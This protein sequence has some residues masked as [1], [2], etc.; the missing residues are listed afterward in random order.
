MAAESTASAVAALLHWLTPF[1]VWLWL[2]ESL[3]GAGYAL[4]LLVRA[5]RDVRHRRASRLNGALTTAAYANLRR[6]QGRLVIFGI[7]LFIGLCALTLTHAPAGLGQ[8]VLRFAYVLAFPALITLLAVLTRYDE[9]S[10][11]RI[12]RQ[13]ER[14]R[15][16]KMASAGPPEQAA[17]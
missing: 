11:L 6:V 12:R 1:I 4:R 14:R 10:D 15:A 17:P 3:L 16:L 13:L 5:Q 2:G 9:V 7:T 8:D